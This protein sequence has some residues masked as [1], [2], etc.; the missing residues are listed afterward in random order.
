MMKRLMPGL[1]RTPAESSSCWLTF[2]VL[3]R[4]EV[5]AVRQFGNVVPAEARQPAVNFDLVGA[6]LLPRLPLVLGQD[7]R[8]FPG[9][10]KAGLPDFLQELAH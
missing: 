7:Q 6:H 9:A 10:K 8:F 1:A 3:G 2:V 5:A 4:G